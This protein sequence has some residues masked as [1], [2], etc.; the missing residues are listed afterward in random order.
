VSGSGVLS[1]SWSL[2]IRGRILPAVRQKFHLAPC[3]KIRDHL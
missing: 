3:A 1:S 2:L